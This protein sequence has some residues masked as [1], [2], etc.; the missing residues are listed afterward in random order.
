VPGSFEVGFR[1]VVFP[2]LFLI[3][4]LS[5][6]VLARFFSKVVHAYTLFVCLSLVLTKIFIRLSDS[7]F[8]PLLLFALSGHIIVALIRICQIAKR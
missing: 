1:D 7:I 5:L 8:I 2:L 3:L 6:L 4:S